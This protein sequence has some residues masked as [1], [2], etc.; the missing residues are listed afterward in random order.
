VPAIRR[1]STGSTS[2]I[3][4]VLGD[5]LLIFRE[6]QTAHELVALWRAKMGLS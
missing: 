2:S 6:E 5:G 1:T 4:G 3:Y